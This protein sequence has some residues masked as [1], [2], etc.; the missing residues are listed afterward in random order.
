MN[1]NK[2]HTTFVQFTKQKYSKK[3]KEAMKILF[4]KNKIQKKKNKINC[5]EIYFCVDLNDC[6]IKKKWARRISNEFL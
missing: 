4:N 2:Q 1:N 5:L 3:I 6:V